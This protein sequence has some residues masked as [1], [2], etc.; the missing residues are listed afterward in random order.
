MTQSVRKEARSLPAPG[1]GLSPG[2]AHP[3]PRDPLWRGVWKEQGR[4][5]FLWRWLEGEINAPWGK[6]GTLFL[7][8]HAGLCWLSALGAS[9]SELL[10]MKSWPRAQIAMC[11]RK[12]SFFS[13][14]PSPQ[15]NTSTE[16]LRISGCWPFS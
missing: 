4:G 1:S 9:H 5:G 2:S 13:S 3:F 14:S 11:P 6:P 7:K 16:F 12:S 10:C 15:R 8:S